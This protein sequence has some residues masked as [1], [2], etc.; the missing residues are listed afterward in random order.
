MPRCRR[1]FDFTAITELDGNLPYCNAHG[2]EDSYLCADDLL[3]DGPLSIVPSVRKPQLDMAHLVEGAILTGDNAMAE[4]GVGTGKTY[5]YLVPA[6]GSGKRVVISTENKNLLDQITDKDAPTI[7]RIFASFGQDKR[8]VALKGAANYGC[9]LKWQKV[10]H[11]AKDKGGPGAKDRERVKQWFTTST[12]G[13]FRELDPPIEFAYRMDATSCVGKNCTYFETC[14]FR[15]NRADARLADCVITTH[16]MIAS[17]SRIAN[18]KTQHPLIGDYNV[19]IA[20]EAHKLEEVFTDSWGS[21]TNVKRL[22]QLH[23]LAQQLESVY[24][25]SMSAAAAQGAESCL[26]EALKKASWTTDKPRILM[27]SHLQEVQ[28][29]LSD[30]AARIHQASADF[31]SRHLRLKRRVE[32]KDNL[33]EIFDEFTALE[34]YARKLGSLVR[35]VKELCFPED[36]FSVI[37]WEKTPSGES[38]VKK[39]LR[40]DAILKQTLYANKSSVILTSATL[41]TGGSFQNAMSDLGLRVANPKRHTM[42]VPSPFD[43]PNQC[44]SY[45]ETDPAL[46]PPKESDDKSLR[47]YHTALS[48]RIWDLAKITGGFMFVLFTNNKDLRAV[49]QL[50][51][52]GVYPV[53][54]QDTQVEAAKQT[55]RR[56]LSC[57]YKER[58]REPDVTKRC[59][60]ILLGVD[61]FWSG[62]SVPGPDLLSVVIPK[63]P[64]QVP[65]DPVHHKKSAV[66]TAHNINPWVRLVEPY[67]ITRLKQGSGRLIRTKDD[68]GIVACL[69]ARRSNTW[70]GRQWVP[71]GWKKDMTQDMPVCVNRTEDLGAVA[72]WWSGKQ[73]ELQKKEASW[74]AA[75]F[76]PPDGVEIEDTADT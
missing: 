44:I 30:A 54:A 22:Q 3:S 36:N 9:K 32:E 57:S 37:Y 76:S 59:G 58:M 69:D 68:M 2:Y 18:A 5:A 6:L 63:V 33:E 29:V 15:A 75:G 55:L 40:V 31:T 62:V 38:I 74:A 21:T 43:Y 8:I 47:A 35:G 70:D 10:Q 60:P 24:G 72:S 25:V 17:E 41:A 49:E 4:A 19:F 48:R 16:A 42:V 13:E 1:C 51:A 23:A 14:G 71:G 11:I 66:L 52:R 46:C 26:A 64:F 20:D 12:Y 56:Y 65:T 27:G 7:A 39:P 45:F 34:D 28:K 61:S 53:F 50:L 67:A 73:S